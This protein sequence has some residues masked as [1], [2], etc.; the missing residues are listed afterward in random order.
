VELSANGRRGKK[1]AT[2]VR[3]GTNRPSVHLLEAGL[4]QAGPSRAEEFRG[5]RPASEQE[6]GP[7][8]SVFRLAGGRRAGAGRVAAA[9]DVSTDA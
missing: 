7:S 3:F 5:H 1:E 8:R 9:A 2:D 4:W 6:A